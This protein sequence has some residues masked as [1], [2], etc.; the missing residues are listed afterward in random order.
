MSDKTVNTDT[1]V[2]STGYLQKLKSKWE[3]EST[4][5]VLLVLLV[6][7][8]T[9]SSVVYLRKALFTLMGFDA[10][11]AFWLKTVTY[12]LFVLPSYQVLLLV[13]GFIFGQFNFFWNKEKKMFN[14]IKKL[15]VRR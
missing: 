7:S 5:Q 4:M 8:L 13:Y 1:T 15:F 6:F 2:A 3:L 11:T 9:G 10:D 12:I 14:N